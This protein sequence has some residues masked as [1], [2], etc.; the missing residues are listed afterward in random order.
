MPFSR[1][2][3]FITA[4]LLA[5]CAQA[6][7]KNPHTSPTPKFKPAPVLVTERYRVPAPPVDKN[8]VIMDFANAISG[9]DG[10]PQDIGRKVSGRPIKNARAAEKE[11]HETVLGF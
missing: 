6:R 4:T 7:A 3:F 2:L 1:Q 10:T 11:E 8:T 9:T 5:F